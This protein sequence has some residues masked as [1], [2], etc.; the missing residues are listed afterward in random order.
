[1]PIKDFDA[2]REPMISVRTPVHPARQSCDRATRH[3]PRQINFGVISSR[4]ALASQQGTLGF[5]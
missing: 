2:K 4:V 1:L 3:G 5:L